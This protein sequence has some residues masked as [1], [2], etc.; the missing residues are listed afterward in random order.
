MSYLAEKLKAALIKSEVARTAAAEAEL[1]ESILDSLTV[2]SERGEIVSRDNGQPLAAMIDGMR[3]TNPSY[4]VAPKP[5][6]PRVVLDP[7]KP[8]FNL[9][10]AIAAARTDPELYAELLKSLAPRPTM[11]GAM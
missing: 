10:A 8:N 5:A 4:F 1:V 11:P 9:T 3:K 7:T 2:V 6:A